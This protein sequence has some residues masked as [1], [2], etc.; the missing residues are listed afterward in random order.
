MAVKSTSFNPVDGKV[1]AGGRPVKLPKVPGGD[2]A[3]LVIEAD[4]TSKA[5]S[6]LPQPAMITA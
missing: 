4:P 2:L 3:G 6:L 5:C 1:R